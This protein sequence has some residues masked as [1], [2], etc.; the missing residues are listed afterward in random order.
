MRLKH[1]VAPLL[2]LFAFTLGAQTTN[3]TFTGT[4]YLSAVCP[5]S[6][7]GETNCTYVGNI[8]N[9]PAAAYGSITDTTGANFPAINPRGVPPTINTTGPWSGPS[10]NAVLGWQDG[11]GH[12]GTT[13]IASG[14]CTTVGAP[15][16]SP[17]PPHIVSPVV[18]TVTCSGIDTNGFP[19]SK[20]HSYDV[21]FA[22]SR[23]GGF[24]Q[25]PVDH[26]FANTTFNVV[27]PYVQAPLPPP[28]PPPPPP[29]GRGDSSHD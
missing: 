1:S 15:V 27:L 20:V 28:P 3:A 6:P 13:T 25:P 11:M 4:H 26:P 24:W 14:T 12:S 17:Y 23:A 5:S 29:D 10:G 8:T 16:S 2:V 21:R 19:A 22:T 9:D 18:Y 7:N